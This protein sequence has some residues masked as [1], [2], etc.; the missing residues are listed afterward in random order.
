MRAF[1]RAEPWSPSMRVRELPRRLRSWRSTRWTSD[2]AALRRFGDR[3]V[4]LDPAYAGPER[5]LVGV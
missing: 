1:A 4:K 5:R 3:R 2:R